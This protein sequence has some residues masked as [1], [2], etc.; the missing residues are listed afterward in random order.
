MSKS[1]TSWNAWHTAIEPAHE[2]SYIVFWASLINI[3]CVHARCSHDTLILLCDCTKILWR[4]WQIVSW[5]T[6]LL[7]ISQLVLCISLKFQCWAGGQ[8]LVFCLL[9]SLLNPLHVSLSL[10]A[11]PKMHP[12][13]RLNQD[14]SGMPSP[15]AWGK[16]GTYPWGWFRSCHNF[17]FW[18]YT[19]KLVLNHEI[20]IF[21]L[22][23]V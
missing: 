16:F 6:K 21:R 22:Y 7:G 4:G 14:A 11:C 17:E 23:Y 2:R 3:R 5:T 1:T 20:C 13:H 12:G 19:W 15:Q 9:A 10:M 18:P 8:Y